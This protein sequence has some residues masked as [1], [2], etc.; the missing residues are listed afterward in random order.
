MVLSGIRQGY[1]VTI[2]FNMYAYVLVAGLEKSDLGCHV[3]SGY[4]GCIAYA[5]DILISCSVTI[6]QKMLAM[7]V[8]YGIICLILCLILKSYSCL[9]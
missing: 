7:C 1:F 5:D 8:S 4:I 2:V 6:L 3:C 9:R